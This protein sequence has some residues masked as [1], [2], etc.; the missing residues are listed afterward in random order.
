MPT[1]VQTVQV[2]LSISSLLADP[3][4]DDPLEADVAHTYKT[5]RSVE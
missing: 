3:N 1:I 2:L 4:A 5:N